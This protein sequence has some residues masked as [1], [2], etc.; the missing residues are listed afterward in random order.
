[1]IERATFVGA[2]RGYI[3][4]PFFHC[5]RIPGVAMDCAGVAICALEECGYPVTDHIIYGQ[6][7]TVDDV[8]RWLSK[9]ACPKS[10]EDA[11]PGDVLTSVYQG[12]LG[13]LMVL[14]GEV[15]MA[16]MSAAK[17]CKGRCL[18]AATAALR[19]SGLE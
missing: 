14:T 17:S 1:M 8:D 4:T 9:Y 18:S 12:K 2:V 3:G 7:P 10:M 6:F 16:S 13:H 11:L 15:S 19:T 5:G